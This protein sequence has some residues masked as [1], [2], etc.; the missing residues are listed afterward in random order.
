[1]KNS[2]DNIGNRTRDLPV[3]SAVPQLTAPPRA[4][5]V[6][7]TPVN[8]TGFE[9]DSP[10]TGVVRGRNSG[11]FVEIVGELRG[12]FAREE[13]DWRRKFVKNFFYKIFFS[14]KFWCTCCVVL[15]RLRL[16]RCLAFWSRNY[17][18]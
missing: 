17:F 18:F 4:P 10:N 16:G 1:M 14:A 8:S 11:Q 5:S 15:D 12:A 3:C 2:S 6:Q 9:V 7:G 13:T